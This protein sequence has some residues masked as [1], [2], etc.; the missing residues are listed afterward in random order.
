M[1]LILVVYTLFFLWLGI[2]RYEACRTQAGDLAIF[3]CAF[4]STLKGEVFWAFFGNCSYFAFHPEPL[5]FL[6][7]PAFY[8]FPSP[9]TLIVIQSICIAVA[10]IP[11]YLLG[12]KL[13]EREAVGVLMALGFLLFPT[14][15]S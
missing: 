5:L 12:R 14:I 1:T 8:I 2:R 4:Y 15:V 9:R 10:S 6:F 7:V 11:V 3:D 13:L